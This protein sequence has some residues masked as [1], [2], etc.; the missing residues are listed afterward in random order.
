MPNNKEINEKKYSD[1]IKV[2]EAVLITQKKEVSLTGRILK[3]ESGN[4]TITD[5]GTSLKLDSK[6]D[7][8]RLNLGDFVIVNGEFNSETPQNLSIKD[9]EIVSRCV[10]PIYDVKNINNLGSLETVINNNKRETLLL[11]AKVLKEIRTF[12]DDKGFIELETPIL[13]YSPSTSSTNVLT[14]ESNI[15]HHQYL[16]RGSPEKQLVRMGLGFNKFYE[17]GKSFRDGEIDH[18]HSPEFTLV[19]YYSTF[20]D[21]HDI[22][23]LTEEIIESIAIKIKG[24]TKLPFGN[25]LIDVKRPWKR[26]SVRDISKEQYGFDVVDIPTDKL[27]EFLNVKEEMSRGKLLEKFMGDKLEPCFEQPTFMMDFPVD[28]GAPAKI[29]PSDE[30]IMERAELF[31]AGGMELANLYTYCI[32]P[33]F[34]RKHYEKYITLKFG[35]ENLEKN[36]D[37]EF[38]YE[39]GCGIPPLAVGGFGI[40]RLV[41]LLSNEMD[42]NKT[43]CYSFKK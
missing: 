29:K 16:L 23:D 21:Y 33:E 10:N 40:D 32:D 14:T 5:E 6:G 22:M 38:L 37:K 34:F 4:Y 42:I 43:M 2:S 8:S 24:T 30:K 1:F 12:L 31:F 18:K 20:S 41:M 19:E 15:N 39:M 13:R 17:M 27:K 9:V 35:K 36:L 7:T 26:V 3:D 28:I 11:R 25:Y